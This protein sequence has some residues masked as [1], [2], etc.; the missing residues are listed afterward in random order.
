MSL[1]MA[2]QCKPSG[3]APP[4]TLERVLVGGVGDVRPCER[5]RVCD[6]GCVGSRMRLCLCECVGKKP[7]AGRVE[8]MSVVG[9]NVK[10]RA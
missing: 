4:C 9:R 2:C 10:E 7:G 8:R 3:G 1:L 5:A 6:S